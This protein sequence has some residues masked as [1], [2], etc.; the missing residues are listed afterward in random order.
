M[1]NNKKILIFGLARSGYE[2]AKLLASKNC[3]VLVVDQKKQDEKKVNELNKLGVKVLII[4]DSPEDYLDSS[5]DFVVKNPGVKLDHAICQ[6]ANKLNIKLVSE[7]E[8]A[9]SYLKEKEV[10]IIAV[11]GSNGK[12]TT[13]TLIYELL[14]EAKKDVILGGNLGFPVCSLVNKCKKGTILVLEIAGHHLHDCYEFK[15]NVSVMTNLYE[16]HIDHFGSFENYKKNKAKIFNNHTEE[17]VAIYNIGNKDVIEVVKNIPSHKISFTSTDIESDLYIKNEAIYYKDMEIIKCSDILLKGNHNYENIM[18]AIAAS[19][20]YGV[21]NEDIYNVLSGFSSVEHRIEY[22]RTYKG[23]DFYNDSKSTNVE[24]TITALK[25]FNQ[26]IYLLLGGFDR[27]HSFDN[28]L[29]YMKSVKMVATYGET[30]E[31]IKGFC[32]KNNIPCTISERLNEAVK[33]L[34]EKAHSNSV[35]LLSPACAS[36][37]QYD[38]F[39]DRGD[40]FK[41]IILELK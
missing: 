17:D 10:E 9:Y 24:A 30:K 21:S 12:T 34:V 15:T 6:K 1:F 25:S 19:K 18:C 8:V 23:I 2:C 32:D 11:T 5:F 31:R 36:W 20:Q 26:D 14:K 7:V 13:T 3:D 41:K 4:P 38:K 16:V 35:I 22:V 40:D 29:P 27:K 28:L 33:S 39:E 37:D